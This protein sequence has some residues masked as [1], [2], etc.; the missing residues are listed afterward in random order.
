MRNISLPAM[1][2]NQEKQ[3]INSSKDGF[4]DNSKHS[5]SKKTNDD[6]GERLF[7]TGLRVGEGNPTFMKNKDSLLTNITGD[8]INTFQFKNS[9]F[10]SH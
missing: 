8:D 4:F 1:G 6:T 3:M 9:T 5:L 10:A 7:E 2:N